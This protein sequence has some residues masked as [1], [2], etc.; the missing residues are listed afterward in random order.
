MASSQIPISPAATSVPK[1]A[2]TVPQASVPPQPTTTIAPTTP[3]PV[4]SQS[5][6][7][8]SARDSSVSYSPLTYSTIASAPQPTTAPQLPVTPA[9]KLAEP[10]VSSVLLPIPIKP[11]EALIADN[12]PLKEGSRMGSTAQ[13]ATPTIPTQKMENSQHMGTPDANYR[14]LGQQETDVRSSLPHMTLIAIIAAIAC[15]SLFMGISIWSCHR[16]R[17]RRRAARDSLPYASNYPMRKDPT[18]PEKDI[19]LAKSDSSNS[20]PRSSFADTTPHS[21]FCE[22]FQYGLPVVSPVPKMSVVPKMGAP[23][24]S[25]NV[26]GRHESPPTMR[27]GAQLDR[28]PNCPEHLTFVPKILLTGNLLYPQQAFTPPGKALGFNDTILIKTLPAPRSCG[29]SPAE[30]SKE[31]QKLIEQV[32]LRIYEDLDMDD[33]YSDSIDSSTPE[34]FSALTGDFLPSGNQLFMMNRSVPN[35]PLPL[36][37]YNY[38]K[39]TRLQQSPQIV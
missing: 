32:D 12:A 37:R 4:P 31:L 16:K 29:M 8:S 11:T 20:P 27:G 3:S 30:A 24:G 7:L 35:L 13:L 28:L 9:A 15:A 21:K 5:G 10:M 18:S 6:P 19:S 38:R 34:S 17:N 36:P 33:S 1:S 23:M 25:Y 2:S 22:E 14:D 26:N 39:I